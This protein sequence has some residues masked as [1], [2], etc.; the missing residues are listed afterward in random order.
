MVRPKILFDNDRA[1]IVYHTDAWYGEPRVSVEARLY[2]AAV[3]ATTAR[4]AVLADIFTKLAVHAL[5]DKTYDAELAKLSFGLS[6]RPGG[7]AL[8]L[9]GFS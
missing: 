1:F 9:Y 3:M 6:S 8:Q 5:E 2:S 7:L 4:E